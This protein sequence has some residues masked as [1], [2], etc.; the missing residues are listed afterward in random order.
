MYKIIPLSRIVFNMYRNYNLV[1][2][3]IARVSKIVF[4]VALIYWI[5][6]RES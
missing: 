2:C 5:N 3:A 1:L 4:Q 6:S